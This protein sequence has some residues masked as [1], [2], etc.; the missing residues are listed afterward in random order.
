M[1]TITVHDKWKALVEYIYD[2]KRFQVDLLDGEPESDLD[3]MV[4]SMGK[5]LSIEIV[6]STIPFTL[7]VDLETADIILTMLGG[8]VKA[9]KEDWCKEWVKGAN[10]VALYGFYWKIQ[11]GEF[12]VLR[13]VFS[14][15]TSLTTE[16]F[17]TTVIDL[18]DY[19]SE[20]VYYVHAGE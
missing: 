12:L 4:V 13:N 9:G 3:T 1:N 2:D 19:G 14:M 17:V 5:R 20:M 11:H 10:D 7:E 18:V 15:I 8:H 6:E 16:E